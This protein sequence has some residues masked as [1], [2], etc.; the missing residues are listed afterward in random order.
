MDTRVHFQKVNGF[1]LCFG[2][3]CKS[4]KRLPSCINT[5]IQYGGSGGLCYHPSVHGKIF[6]SALVL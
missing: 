3:R 4:D 5:N 6:V 2:V 1:F